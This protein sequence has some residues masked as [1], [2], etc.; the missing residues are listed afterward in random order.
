MTTEAL[1]NYG[2]VCN[3]PKKTREELSVVF[4]S[5]I[6]VTLFQNEKNQFLDIK[7]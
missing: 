5:L 4:C 6:I 3:P 7:Y 1:M 2:S